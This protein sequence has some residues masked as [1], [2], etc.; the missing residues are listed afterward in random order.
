[1]PEALYR[2]EVDRLPVE[3]YADNDSLGQAAA[4]RAAEILL[5]ALKNEEM[6]NL[7]VA[8]GNSQLSFYTHLAKITDIPWKRVRI[9]HMDEYVGMKP[10]HPASFRRYLLEK[11]VYKVHP[12]AFYG[13]NGDAPDSALECLRY[14]SLL[15]QYPAHLCC[16]GIG[17][18]GHIAF[19]DPPF[20][21]FNDPVLVK[22]VTL[23]ERSRKQQVGEGHF[24]SLAKVPTQ[25]I[26]LTIPALLGARQVLAI[27]PEKRKAEAVRA[28]LTGPLTTACP[29]SILRTVPNCRLYLDLES[30]ALIL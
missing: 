4:A 19:N 6:A 2:K 26:T 28:A 25:A 9:F 10:D 18:N 15:S 22:V 8:T 21:N 14:T 24:S 17:E 16:L 20:A 11:L 3:I 29:A 13:V 30:A 5:A 1:M 12:A 7:I 27:V 23:D